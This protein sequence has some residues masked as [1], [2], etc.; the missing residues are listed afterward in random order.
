MFSAIRIATLFL[1]TIS[2]RVP[3][4]VLAAHKEFLIVGRRWDTEITILGISKTPDWQNQIR[5]LALKTSKQRTPDWIDYFAF[6]RGLFKDLPPLVV[7]RVFWD[8]WTVW[9]ALQMKKPVVDASRGIIAVHQN[10]D[11]G[12]HPQGKARRVVSEKKREP[13]INWPADG[14]ISALSPIRMKYCAPTD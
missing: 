6:S 2:V 4:R 8:N 5:D 14:T 10:H 3:E 9:K 1:C 13:I 11:Y 7:G 12:H